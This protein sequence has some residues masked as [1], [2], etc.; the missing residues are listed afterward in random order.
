MITPFIKILQYRRYKLLGIEI[1]LSDRCSSPALL[2]TSV[3]RANL[4][5]VVATTFSNLAFLRYS[6]SMANR[7][8]SVATIFSLAKLSRSVTTIFS[9]LAFH[10]SSVSM[11]FGSCLSLRFSY[12]RFN[13]LRGAR[14]S[15]LWSS[16]TFLLYL[17]RFLSSA[18]L[19][20]CSSVSEALFA[21]NRPKLT[22]SMRVF[23]L[24]NSTHAFFIYV[25]FV[26]VSHR[27]TY[28][29]IYLK[30]GSHLLESELIP[31]SMSK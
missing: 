21:L 29:H 6:V 20:L 25:L 3:S 7:S 30:N 8:C 16:V 18:F 24:C 5:C 4:S 9:S 13:I 19:F 12:P 27:Q 10:S 28:I 14:G 1:G 11:T 15:F 2:F 22:L 17:F 31:K 26:W 23:G